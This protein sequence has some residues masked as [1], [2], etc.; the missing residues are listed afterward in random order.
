MFKGISRIRKWF[1]IS[2]IIG[3]ILIVW[4]VYLKGEFKGG[5]SL[6]FS[7]KDIGRSGGA[8]DNQNIVIDR[9]EGTFAVCFRADNSVVLINRTELP[10]EIIEGD[11]LIRQETGYGIDFADRKRRQE[12]LDKLVNELW[13]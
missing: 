7:S 1:W 11:L 13:E 5:S 3:S 10:K 4:F 9:F 2:A 12:V 6:V 8:I